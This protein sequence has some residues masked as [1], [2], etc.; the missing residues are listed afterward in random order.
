MN[1][2]EPKLRFPSMP[3][4]L[5]SPSIENARAVRARRVNL[6]VWR[7]EPT[8]EYSAHMDAL[9]LQQRFSL[10]FTFHTLRPDVQIQLETLPPGP[11]HDALAEDIAM[12]ANYFAV[13]CDRPLVRIRLQSMESAGDECFRISHPAL[14]LFVTYSGFGSQW[15]ANEDVTRQ[16]PRAQ[17][18]EP[19]AVE[20][21]GLRAGCRV[22]VARP[23]WVLIMKGESYRGN[24]GNGIVYR[25]SPGGASRR[26][27]MY[28]S[29]DLMESLLEDHCEQRRAAL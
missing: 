10:D 2:E 28:L 3:H 13:A 26:P 5:W 8:P 22:H 29:I 9:C 1:R 27:R 17:R 20:S 23:W 25:A 18:E 7:R 11:A 12:L 15:I 19:G 6:F 4:V 21:L 14:R 24:A 16:I